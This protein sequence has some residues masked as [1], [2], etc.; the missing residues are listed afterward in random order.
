M[1]LTANPYLLPGLESG[2]I[3]VARIAETVPADHWDTPTAPGRFTPR[4]VVAHLADWET[5]LLKRMQIA[6]ATPGAEVMA[7][8][9]GVWAVEH[10]YASTDPKEQAALF[11][12]RRSQTLAWLKALEPAD[13]T[14]TFLH[15]EQGAKTIYDCACM[16]L[17]HDLYHIEQLSGVAAGRAVGTW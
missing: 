7:Y 13:W 8:D 5:E 11:R 1:S 17:G 3:V 16:M 6:K 4:E 14:L 12:S 2:P 15:P 9:E 10:G